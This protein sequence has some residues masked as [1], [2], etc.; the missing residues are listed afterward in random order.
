M[1]PRAHRTIVQPLA[2]LQV[3]AWNVG[4]CTAQDLKQAIEQNT[5]TGKQVVCLLEIGAWKND[6]MIDY[7]QNEL[8][9][10]QWHFNCESKFDKVARRALKSC[11]RKNEDP[12]TLP[13]SE[14][15]AIEERTKPT[16]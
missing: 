7:I 4:N 15:E 3:L 11:Q 1:H 8:P 9:D 10:Y 13:D 5:F 2:P 6:P 12:E 14:W 16:S